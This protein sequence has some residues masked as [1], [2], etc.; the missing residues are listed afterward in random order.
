MTYKE[1]KTL[2]NE[3][4]VIRKSDNRSLYVIS[5]NITDNDVTL[6]CDD[7]NEYHHTEVD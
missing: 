1:A 5:V 3:D 2:H 4:E 6:L 7:G